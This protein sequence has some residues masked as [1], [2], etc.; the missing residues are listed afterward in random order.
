MLRAVS[1]WLVRFCEQ[2]AG[3]NHYIQLV[4]NCDDVQTWESGSSSLITYLLT[5]SME[6]NPSRE[7]DRFSA[8]QEIPRILWNPKVHYRIHK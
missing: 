2:K 5:Y 4:W 6:Q 8:G 3:Q 1:K 7:A